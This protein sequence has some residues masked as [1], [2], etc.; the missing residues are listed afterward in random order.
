[1]QGAKIDGEANLSRF[2]CPIHRPFVPCP[3]SHVPLQ[4][5]GYE[6]EAY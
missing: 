5:G 1:M 3:L 4:V 6:S 2:S